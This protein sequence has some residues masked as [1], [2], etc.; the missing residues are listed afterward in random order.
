MSYSGLSLE[1]LQVLQHRPEPV[2]TL[3]VYKLCE[4]RCVLLKTLLLKF[5]PRSTA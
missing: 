5:A 4:V 3:V 1:L 2:L